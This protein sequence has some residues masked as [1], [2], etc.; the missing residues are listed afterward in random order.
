MCSSQAGGTEPSDLH[1]PTAQPTKSAETKPE[2]IV[3]REFFNRFFEKPLPTATFYDKVNE[4]QIIPWPEMRGRYFLNASLRRL[5]LPPVHELP[6]VMSPNQE[7]LVRLAFSLIDQHL[8]PA[9]PWLL[10]VDALNFEDMAKAT[11]IVRTHRDEV[12]QRDHYLL[13]LAYFQGVLDAA[14]MTAKSESGGG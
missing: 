8:F 3:S 5:R 9:P 11:K 10:A 1:Q 4:G 13:K 2:F 6:K 14:V 12:A 7:D